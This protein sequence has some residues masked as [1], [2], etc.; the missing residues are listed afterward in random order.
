MIQKAVSWFFDCL[1]TPFIYGACVWSISYKDNSVHITLDHTDS[2]TI[3][4]SDLSD[5]VGKY[6]DLRLSR[7]PDSRMIIEDNPEMK[8][9]EKQLERDYK[10]HRIQKVNRESTTSE[11]ITKYR[12]IINRER[13]FMNGFLIEP[14]LVFDNFSNE[15]MIDS[16][17]SDEQTVYPK[18]EALLIGC[19]YLENL[20]K[21]YQV[22]PAPIAKRRDDWVNVRVF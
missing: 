16:V 11:Q 3:A 4:L 8:E 10:Q 22:S 7:H 17:Y 20:E 18:T 6:C 15:N 13:Y 21:R 5:F 9:L 1:K 2:G 14:D 12:M 19:H